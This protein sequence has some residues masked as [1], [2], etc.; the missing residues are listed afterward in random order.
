MLKRVKKSEGFYWGHGLIVLLSVLLT[1]LVWY[2]IKKQE[3][4]KKYNRFKTQAVQV[5]SLIQE[6][7]N[8]YENAL[9]A[10]R[11]YIETEDN[12][13]NKKNWA[14]YTKIL[15]IDKR[16]PGI[17]G[18]GIIYKFP[19]KDKAKYEKFYQL[20]RPYF[21]IYPEHNRKDTIPIVY[22]EPE[23]S[24]RQAVGLD[25][26]HETNRYHAALRAEA[27]GE[28]QITGPIILV[29][30]D[31]KT[32]GFLFYVPMYHDLDKQEQL[33]GFVY[34]PFIMKKL[35]NGV[36]AEKN[37]QVAIKITDDK[38]V[39]YDEITHGDLAGGEFSHYKQI[40]KQ[41]VYGRVWT[42]TVVPTERF[43]L[44]NKVSSPLLILLA[45]ILID[46]LLIYIFISLSKQNKKVSAHAEKIT[47]DLVEKSKA[48]EKLVH[49]N[50][51][52]GLPNRAYFLEEL[53]KLVSE[54][55]KSAIA[56]ILINVDDFQRINDILSHAIGDKLLTVV[57][58]KLTR[59][60]SGDNYFVSHFGA[61]D[62]GVI[63][64]KINSNKNLT[65]LI[66]NALK[67]FKNPLLIDSY[68][69]NVSISA[70]V[71][72][73]PEN[74][75][76]VETLMIN[77][78]IAMFYIKQHGK[79]NY[80]FYDDVINKEVLRRHHLFL[81]LENALNKKEFYLE[82]QPQVDIITKNI[83]GFEA[84]LRWKNET[85]GS[86]SPV[87]F[88]PLIEETGQIV[89]I[90]HWVIEQ[91]LKDFSSIQEMHKDKQLR[92]SI[93]ASAIELQQEN[94]VAYIK[95]KLNQYNIL[96]AS[97][98]IEVTESILLNRNQNAVDALYALKDFGVQC[99]LDDYGT[100]YASIQYL[101]EMPV[102]LVKL[103]KYFVKELEFND[104]NKTI[105]KHTIK[106]CHALGLRVLAE[107]VE[108]HSQL[109][110]LLDYHC[111]YIQ[112]FYFY[113]PMSLANL[114]L[115]FRS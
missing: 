50:V 97:V 60:F 81:A 80:R 10:A 73:Y 4:A 89:K 70:G 9:L 13:I 83:I 15:S 72:L 64:R 46:L 8:K 113:R 77:A 69:L 76:T 65:K 99:A 111:D 82:Y 32:P 6:R 56:V 94:Y 79:K 41:P 86:I 107:G 57:S 71:S 115:L 45:G 18:I 17:N 11:A 100:G 36:L 54:K 52:T 1:I 42:Y 14:L 114:S 35:I 38:S 58:Q 19:K 37:R 109:E 2:F 30:D 44:A 55:P 25:M 28:P 34:A 106:L 101:K 104:E 16:Y 85:F 22:I 51:L 7:M 68:P 84:L 87:E 39:F 93:N 59:A 43:E 63:I 62:F 61:D 75:E 21:K 102:S 40:I 33:L 105:I 24:N 31:E 92:L 48:L 90:G 20:E 98:Y 49:F 5:V 74:A 53:K 66:E 29:Q 95:Q 108:T 110:L 112:G 23:E 3:E 91:A 103:D 27:S 67:N 12:K 96:P 78:G 88:I 26:A 47:V